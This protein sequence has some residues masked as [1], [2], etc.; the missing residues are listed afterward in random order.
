M[1]HNL[2]IGALTESI[3]LRDDTWVS[4]HANMLLPDWPPVHSKPE[5]EVM[6]L[7]KDALSLQPCRV[8]PGPSPGMDE[9]DDA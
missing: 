5:L 3:Q 4:Q 1:L 6:R 7:A 8:G 2:H 9:D